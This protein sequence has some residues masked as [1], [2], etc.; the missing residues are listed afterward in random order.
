MTEKPAPI[1]QILING[2][3]SLYPI[4]AARLLNTF[5]RKEVLN[6]LEAMPAEIYS[7]IFPLLN[8]D[9]SSGLIEYM[10]KSFFQKLFGK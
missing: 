5:S 1:N 9:F 6:Y 8:P 3:F 2:Y 7:K 10:E 4:E